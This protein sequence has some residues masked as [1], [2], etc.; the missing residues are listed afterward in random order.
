MVFMFFAQIPKSN[1]Q[2]Q[3]NYASY[4]FTNIEGTDINATIKANVGVLTDGGIALWGIE[5]T[6]ITNSTLTTVIIRGQINGSTYNRGLTF[7]SSA[8]F[9]DDTELS[10]F[11]NPLP[12]NDKTFTEIIPT[13]KENLLLLPD[14]YGIPN[15]FSFNITIFVSNSTTNQT[16]FLSTIDSPLVTIIFR[17]PDA[18]PE[19]SG[20]FFGLM[21][22]LPFI[23]PISVIIVFLVSNKIQENRAKKKG[24]NKGE[25]RK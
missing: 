13:L 2:A 15:S 11:M 6:F 10:G 23:M 24:G 19:L 20:L 9:N 1:A 14:I 5:P 16:F 7:P 18:S 12:P 17:N 21:Y 25:S 4:E 22:S 8:Q 3:I